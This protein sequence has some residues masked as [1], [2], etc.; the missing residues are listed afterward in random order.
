LNKTGTFWPPASDKVV[1]G[2]IVVFTKG[3]KKGEEGGGHRSEKAQKKNGGGSRGRVEAGERTE[4]KKEPASS[5]KG[6]ETVSPTMRG[7]REGGLNNHKSSQKE[8]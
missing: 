1:S 2:R 7:K 4:T 3:K 6:V 5:S 8:L